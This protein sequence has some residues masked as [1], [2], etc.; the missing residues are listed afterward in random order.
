M[1]TEIN[2]KNKHG[3]A[4]MLFA[5]CSA[6]SL[7]SAAVYLL[8]GADGVLYNILAFLWLATIVSGCILA[9][10][11]RGPRWASF[12]YLS[13]VILYGLLHIVSSYLLMIAMGAMSAG[14]M[15]Y[16]LLRGLP[17]C[18]IFASGC[19]MGIMGYLKPCEKTESSACIHI[20][21][22]I[23]VIVSV[24]VTVYALSFAGVFYM[25][26][27]EYWQFINPMTW[28]AI[29]TAAL[30][31]KL[32]ANT[33]KSILRTCI[34]IIGGLLILLNFVDLN[35]YIARAFATSHANEA[36]AAALHITDEKSDDTD[37][38][39]GKWGL[40]AREEVSSKYYTTPLS[41]PM[42]LCGNRENTHSV[43]VIK[44][45]GNWHEN[46][47]DGVV[48]YYDAYLPANAAEKTPVI[49]SM[50]GINAPRQYTDV[51][52]QFSAMGYAVLDIEYGQ[53]SERFHKATVNSPGEDYTKEN[54]DAWVKDME[55][56]FRYLKT[57]EDELNI[58]LRQTFLLG[59]SYGCW[60]SVGM[61]NL[62]HGAGY[63][64]YMGSH[65]VARYDQLV[66][67]FEGEAAAADVAEFVDIKGMMLLYGLNGRFFADGLDPIIFITG[68]NDHVVP[69]YYANQMYKLRSEYDIPDFYI[70]EAGVTGHGYDIMPG[71]DLSLQLT[72]RYLHMFVDKYSQ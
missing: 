9:V 59:H 19:L 21:S 29:G 32:A 34:C 48:L 6:V 58:D 50:H 30:A 40:F 65:A 1:R 27:F 67:R 4:C 16:V 62:L 56:L 15:A 25:A 61:D 31:W 22:G 38:P 37:T 70:M 69:Y 54:Y 64:D 36:E 28:L 71:C 63:T 57:H 41:L 10:F 24:A 35:V 26:S 53:D 8:T 72:N 2:K 66:D 44:N 11:S 7:I 5:L 52:G 39:D 51:L 49:I 60:M 55:Y 46:S 42:M 20:L 13:S 68:T 12:V 14:G 17:M 3:L 45:A 47:N 33:P 43:Q 23:L 18:L